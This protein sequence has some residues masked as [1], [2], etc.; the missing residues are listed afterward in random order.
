MKR[1][2]LIETILLC[3]IIALAFY[4]AL[5]PRLNYPFPLHV[6]EWMHIGNTLQIMDAGSVTYAEPW[7]GGRVIVEGHPETGYYIWFGTLLFS[8]G[9]PWLALSRLMPALVLGII[10]FAAYALG[11]KHGFGLEAA[12]FATFI[13][14]TIRFLGPALLV[15]VTLGLVFFP[16]S[17]ILLGK[18]EQGWR[19][20]PLIV[21][22]LAALFL[23]HATT[24]AVLGFVLVVNL[25]LYLTLP[26]LKGQQLLP[27]LTSLLLIPASALAVYLWNPALII[28]HAK[29]ILVGSEM[30]LPPIPYPLPQLG[31]IF[32]ALCVLGAGFLV[33]RGGWRNYA[34]V[35]STAILLFFVE[36]YRRWIDT[37][38]EIV[39]ERGWLYAMLFMALIAGYGLSQLRHLS[40]NFFKGRYWG[41]LL[42]Y[43][44]LAVVVGFSLFQRI[45]GYEKE[46]YYRLMDTNTYHDFRFIEEKLDPDS[47]ALL[48]PYLAW[49]FVPIAHKSVYLAIAYPFRKGEAAQIRQFLAGGARDTSWLV[50]RKIDIIYSPF[51]LQN[52]DLVEVYDKVYIL[53]KERG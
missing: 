48:D 20:V 33:A 5:F 14:T 37:G 25:I 49:S 15:P 23:T 11:R 45:D 12:L 6:D 41:V 30:P 17:L 10:A 24:A 19:P 39:Y 22:S 1:S 52:P 44:L 46:N 31:Y 50:K 4:M 29:D 2:F 32:L 34:L 28:K 53:R 9:L 51:Q 7:Q 35:I 13:H 26:R 16:I 27:A 43:V 3:L 47:I 36:I 42:T 8:T 21:L 38:P 18:L 40:I